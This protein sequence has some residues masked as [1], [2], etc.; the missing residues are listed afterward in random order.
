MI[1]SLRQQFNAAFTP[2]R[3]QQMLA[4]MDQDLPGQL[5]FRIA[6]TPIFVPAALRDKLV[7]AGE[8]I[9]A[10]L[11]AP[12]FK[13]RTE[14]AIPASQRVP[15]ENAHP[16]LLALDFAVCRDAAGELVPQLIELQGFASL[17]AFQIFGNFILSGIR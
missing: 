11:M 1:P 13:E 8:D 12:D 4:A 2:A 17:Y 7:A 14:A 3:Y 6:E 9:L 10:V 15:H 16:S 5:D